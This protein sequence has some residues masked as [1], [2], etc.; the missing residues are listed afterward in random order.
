MKI[1]TS[2]ILLCFI[3]NTTM[4]AQH[5]FK[6]FDTSILEI[7]QTSGHNALFHKSIHNFLNNQIDSTYIN[8]SEFLLQRKKTTL[9]DYAYYLKGSCAVKKKLWSQAKESFSQISD[10]FQFNYL[11]KLKLGIIHTNQKEYKKALSFFNE[12]ESEGE[13]TE[14]DSNYGSIYHNIGI[15]H[16]HLKNYKKA[17]AYLYKERNLAKKKNDTL[18]IIYATKDIANAYYEQYLDDKAIPLFKEAYTL[19]KTQSSFELKE[20]T[21][22]NMAVVEKNRKRYKESVEYYVEYIQWKDSLWNR[23]KISSLLKKDKQIAL[24][25]KDKEVAVQKEITNKQKER[26]QLV[27]ISLIGALLFLT[28][29][30]YL[31]RIKTKQHILI[32]TQ[33]E[34]LENLNSTKNYLLSVISHDLRTPVNTLKKQHKKVTELLKINDIN[35]AI[36]LNTKSEAISENTAQTLNNILNW[37]LEQNN[38]LLCMPENHHIKILIDALVFDFTPLALSKNISLSTSFDNPSIKVCLDKELFKIAFRNLIDN[39]IKY[40]PEGGNIW[41]QTILTPEHCIITIKDTGIGMSSEVLHTIN[42]YESLTIEK[43]D[44]SKGLGLG[45]VLSKTLITKNKGELTIANNTDKGI[46]ITLELPLKNDAA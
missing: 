20:N 19:A 15:C 28:L 14:K 16:L 43:I 35:E 18:S 6:N 32:T 29:L 36:T 12:W 3:V 42:T 34:Q 27:T 40:T 17:T 44:R 7:C 45:L 4:S 22:L 1:K 9:S 46:T 24:A 8:I 37:A 26:I 5:N 10:T 39:A 41:I 33:K 30:F 2:I 31:Y 38:Q 13:K 23:D 25:V 11:K 21:T